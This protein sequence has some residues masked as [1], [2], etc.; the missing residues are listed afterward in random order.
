MSNQKNRGGKK[1]SP[2]KSFGTYTV[3]ITDLNHLGCGVGRLPEEARDMAGLVVFV[4]GAVTGDIV[5]VQII[6]QTSS[7]TVGRLLEV[8][9]P[10]PM[11]ETDTFCMAPEACGGCVYRHL[12]YEDELISKHG[13]VA[14]A[15]RMV[16]LA[17][18]VIHPVASTGVTKGYRNKGMYP[19]RQGKNGV[20]AGFFAAKSH[21]LI[22]ACHCSLQPDVFGDVV[23]TICDFFNQKRINL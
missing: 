17:D 1:H 8:V 9:T 14:Q 4:R 15:F 12:K 13:R 3:C 19:V 7:Y 10:S 6:K 20:E 5:S 11:R 21:K 18:V 2:D 23:A 16:G 22:P